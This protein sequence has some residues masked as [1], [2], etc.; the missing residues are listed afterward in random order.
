MQSSAIEDSGQPL[1]QRNAFLVEQAK[2]RDSAELNAHAR[3][4]LNDLE[5]H[6][7]LRTQNPSLILDDLKEL[8]M[9][10]E[11]SE[12]NK[13]I[14][15]SFEDVHRLVTTM[16]MAELIF[17]DQVHF[18]RREKIKHIASQLDVEHCPDMPALLRE[19]EK[20]KYDL[21]QKH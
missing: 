15:M 4:V 9:I 8:G 12:D 14:N 16:K 7:T 10:G 21:T 20:A 3:K 6:R 1:D 5:R 13:F 2:S 11:L 19:L 18:D 17:N